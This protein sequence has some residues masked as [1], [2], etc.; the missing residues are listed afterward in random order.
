MNQDQI[1]SHINQR[2]EQLLPSSL[3]DLKSEIQRNVKSVL[4][5]AFSKM[6][7]ITQEEFDIQSEV[8]AKTRAK[9]E[10]LEKQV[11]QLETLA[12]R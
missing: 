12:H 11:E 3:T 7:V 6:N 10:R 8:L 9:L 5:E 1:F 4:L 2:L